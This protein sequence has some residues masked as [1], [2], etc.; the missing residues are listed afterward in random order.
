MKNFRKFVSMCICLLALAGCS[1]LQ[2]KTGIGGGASSGMSDRQSSEAERF[3]VSGREHYQKGE[4]AEAIDAFEKAIELKPDHY[5]A[6]SSMGVIYSIL[7][8]DELGISFISEAIKLAPS[9]SLLHNNLGYA[10]LK[11]ERNADAADAF[12][13]ALQLDPQNSHAR[14]NLKSAYKQ[15][16]CAAD[17]LCSQ[18]QESSAFQGS[19]GSG[20]IR[21]VSTTGPSLK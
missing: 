15:M 3:Y 8:E 7:G 20:I 19:S 2:Q 17:K 13:R 16:G 5:E 18:W 4:Y 12:E 10:L 11:Q 14:N 21:P 6:Y 1:A 9:L